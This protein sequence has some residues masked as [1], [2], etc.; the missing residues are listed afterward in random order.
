MPDVALGV[1]QRSSEKKKIICSYRASTLVGEITLKSTH[2][3]ISDTE[4]FYEESK[5]RYVLS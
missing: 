4:E 1:V 3:K 2:R 5:T